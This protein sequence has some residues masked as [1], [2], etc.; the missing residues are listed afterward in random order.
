MVKGI[1]FLFL[2]KPIDNEKRREIEDRWPLMVTFL[3]G[4]AGWYYL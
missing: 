1:K 4:Q 2:P 3:V